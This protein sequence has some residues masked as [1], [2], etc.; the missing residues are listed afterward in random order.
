MFS[1][2]IIKKLL[3]YIL[4]KQIKVINLLCFILMFNQ[5]LSVINNWIEL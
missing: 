1:L 3:R 2:I 4:D 5:N